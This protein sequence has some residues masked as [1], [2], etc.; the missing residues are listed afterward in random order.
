[1]RTLKDL[2]ERYDFKTTYSKMRV[3]Y[4]LADYEVLT[5]QEDDGEVERLDVDNLGII[6]FEEP[7][8]LE[9]VFV[10]EY[11]FECGA[12][13][14]GVGWV[15]LKTIIQTLEQFESDYAE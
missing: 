7:E 9:R 13:M 5:Y 12:N 4:L 8:D 2:F 1:M 11:K 15:S 10:N 14:I 6:D 3:A